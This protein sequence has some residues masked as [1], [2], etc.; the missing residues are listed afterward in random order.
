[1]PNT[2]DNA[3]MYAIE[4]FLLDEPSVEAIRL[5]PRYRKRETIQ[6]NAIRA[7]DDNRTYGRAR[8][9][10]VKDIGWSAGPKLRKA[11][12]K[13]GA[14]MME[15][16][17]FK[18]DLIAPFKMQGIADITDSALKAPRDSRVQYRVAN[19]GEVVGAGG[20]VLN[21]VETAQVDAEA[22]RKKGM[23]LSDALGRLAMAS[24]LSVERARAMMKLC[25]VV[26]AR[27]AA[28]AMRFFNCCGRRIVVVDIWRLSEKIQCST[29]VLHG[30]LRLLCTHPPLLDHAPPFFCFR[31]HVG[32]KLLLSAGDNFSPFVGHD[33]CEFR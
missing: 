1:M 21:L 6:R 16:P 26:P 30:L 20:K 25:A 11:A 18:A 10:L 22:V 9:L 19:V 4:S 13:I 33:F 27:S 3:W 14:E 2:P 24:D 29:T 23:E 32:G 17:D 7:L 5:D 31:A 28:R 15:E 12:K 8:A